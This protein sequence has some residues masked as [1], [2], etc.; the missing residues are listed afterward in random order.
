MSRL[1]K[2][3]LL[4]FTYQ[5]HRCYY[6]G[7][8]MWLNSLKELPL[9]RGYKGILPRLKCTAEHLIARQDGGG[10]SRDNIVAACHWCNQ[11]RHSRYRPLDPVR[12]R[13]HVQ[14]RVGKGAW[15][16]LPLFQ[17]LGQDFSSC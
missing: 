7:F 13:Q 14:K 5:N 4:A 9:P 15:H 8:P 16:P 2:A 6:C 17:L 1:Q 11:K 3:R 12:Y 10:D